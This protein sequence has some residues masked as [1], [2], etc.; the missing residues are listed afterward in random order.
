MKNIPR[1]KRVVQIKYKR[2]IYI[3]RLFILFL[4]LFISIIGA[5]SFFSFNKNFTINKIIVTGTSIINPADIISSVNKELSG[6]YYGLYSR[7]NSFIYPQKEIYNNL[8]T[9]FSRI[10]EISITKINFNT[11]Q[12]NIKERLASY[13]YCG[14]IIPDIKSQLG[15]DCYFINDDGYIFGKA[16]YFSGNVYF[17]YYV[18]INNESNPIGQNIFEINQFHKLTYF[19]KGI[20]NLGFKPIYLVINK[21]GIDSLYLAHKTDETTPKIIFDT[22]NNLVNILSNLTTAM[23][24]IE[25][26]KAI[27]SEYNTLLYI[28]L[29]FKDKVLYKF[30]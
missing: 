13:L 1:P 3:L 11:L 27:K 15:E 30:K 6:K 20:T 10:K 18:K 14:S 26:T 19:I 29:R 16:P 24:K 12:I 9:N 2:R 8:I 7:A 28:D 17:K 4:I 5:S 25:F 22:N 23:T 21:D